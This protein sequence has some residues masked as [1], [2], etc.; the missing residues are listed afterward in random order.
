MSP[1]LVPVS[2]L[3]PPEHVAAIRRLGGDEGVS[4]GLRLVVA[5]GLSAIAGGDAA[6]GDAVDE[7][8]GLVD[9]LAAVTGRRTP[10]GAWWCPSDAAL[11]DRNRLAADGAVVAAER[12]VVL[13]G[14]SGALMVDMQ[15]C[16]LEAQNGSNTATQP[17]ELR[18][19]VSIAAL[20]PAALVR[21]SNN[22]PGH[23]QLMEGFTVARLD[24]GNVRFVLHHLP[25]E[26][27]GI[28]A[29]SFSAELLG[30]VARAVGDGIAVRERLNRQLEATR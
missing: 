27:S 8:A 17:L 1:P 28:A 4:S 14:A 6:V 23:E 3:L 15:H 7:L 13:A 19:L 24:T 25:V 18:E 29:L 12:R 2:G 22:G 30:L 21:L 9:R 26:S 11:P 10:S 5:A 20:L 16:A